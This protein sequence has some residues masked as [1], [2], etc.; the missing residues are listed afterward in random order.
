MLSAET[1][2][3]ADVA[4]E[5][6]LALSHPQPCGHSF[7]ILLWVMG[8]E[9]TDI[10]PP[11]VEGDSTESTPVMCPACPPQASLVMTIIPDTQLRIC[12]LGRTWG[13]AQEP[14]EE[15]YICAA[16]APS[17]SSSFSSSSFRPL[18]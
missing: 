10:L 6:S 5:W 17:V 16:E 12:A 18:G 2:L 4:L 15:K 7:V 1:F 3:R 14:C 13:R 11:A 8:L 9:G